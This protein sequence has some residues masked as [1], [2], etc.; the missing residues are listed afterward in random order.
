MTWR[1]FVWTV[2][3]VIERKQTLVIPGIGPFRPAQIVIPDHVWGPDDANW[4]TLQQNAVGKVLRRA[5]PG[6]IASKLIMLV[7]ADT[8]SRIVFVDPDPFFAVEI[9]AQ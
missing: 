6:E 7:H 9:Q 5:E 2:L 3:D 1:D 8:P 4:G